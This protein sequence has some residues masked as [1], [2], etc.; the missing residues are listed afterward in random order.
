MRDDRDHIVSVDQ[1]P[2]DPLNMPPPYW[3]GGGAIFHLEGAVANIEDLLKE[4]LEVHAQTN[5]RL[6]RYWER[7]PDDIQNDAAMD[8]F[9]E[10]MDDLWGLEH[11]IK[12]NGEIA[13]LMSAIE[14]E[15]CVNRFCVFNLHK[16]IAE[17]IE[18]LAPAEKVLIAAAALGE[19][20]VKQSSVFE[21]LRQLTAW[22][23]AFAHGHCVD[24]PLKS[25]RHNHLVAPDDYPGVPSL[26]AETRNLV[27][28][29]L[30]LSD[31]LRVI[32]RNPH[33]K[34]REGNVENVRRS[35]E[36]VACYRFDGDNWVYDVM[37]TGAE[38]AKV[39]KGLL[40]ILESG[41]PE[42]LA[43]LESVLATLDSIRGRIIR[44]ECG[45]EGGRKY[46]FKEAMKLLQLPAKEFDKQR[47][48]A[49]TRLA[50]V[51]EQ[52]ASGAI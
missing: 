50:G 31:Y 46:D 24:R 6:P 14:A 18:R 43:K 39:A 52:I 10:I 12:L 21:G 48:M 40:A 47:A 51:T 8:E 33:T 4:L 29:F 7:Y 1:V 38:Q 27:G 13:C 25:L 5:A 26:V 45:L 11:Q 49:L 41:D 44:L 16:D 37:L 28:A 20:G 34:Q 36:T 42:K 17:S 3:R 19:N 2:D 22:R 30:R 23:N 35:L 15:D 32:S 9:A